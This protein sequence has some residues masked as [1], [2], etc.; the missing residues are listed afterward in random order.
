MNDLA[1]IDPNNSILLESYQLICQFAIKNQ[2]WEQGIIALDKIR[3]ID[4]NSH[5]L[6]E[7]YDNFAAMAGS[8]KNHQYEIFG[9]QKLIEIQPN[10][11]KNHRNLGE[12]YF[13]NQKYEKALEAYTE[14][15]KLNPNDGSYYSL[16]ADAHE[17]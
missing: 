1:T 3:K 13:R 5:S 8:K 17:I 14:A 16:R 11:P 4:P 9:R 15:I 10:N 12:A 2:D 7:E 6:I